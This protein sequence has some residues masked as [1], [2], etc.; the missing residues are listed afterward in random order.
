MVWLVWPL[1]EHLHFELLSFHVWS[2]LS[3]LEWR[4]FQKCLKTRHANSI[5]WDTLLRLLWFAMPHG[6]ESEGLPSSP[7]SWVLLRFGLQGL[8][9]SVGLGFP[10]RS[11]TPWRR[12]AVTPWRLAALA[13]WSFWKCRFMM[14]ATLRWTGEAFLWNMSVGSPGVRLFCGHIWPTNSTTTRWMLGTQLWRLAC[15]GQSR[16]WHTLRQDMAQSQHVKHL[17]SI[18]PVIPVTSRIFRYYDIISILKNEK[19]I[20]YS[21]TRWEIVLRTTGNRVGPGSSPL[22]EVG[23]ISLVWGSVHVVEVCSSISQVLQDQTETRSGMGRD[24]PTMSTVHRCPQVSTGVHLIMCSQG[25]PSVA[26]PRDLKAS[27]VCRVRSCFT[28]GSKEP[29]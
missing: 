1:G 21:V 10:F 16:W 19:K 25:L 4:C 18:S 26:K 8:C 24:L 11:V 5:Y 6:S 9:N 22:G 12:D 3:C 14:R 2:C 7:A 15:C 23:N 27:V 20:I 17:P 28:F 29:S 13:F